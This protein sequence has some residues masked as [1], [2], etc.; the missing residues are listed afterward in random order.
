MVTVNSYM[1]VSVSF[2]VEVNIE[3]QKFINRSIF[4]PGIGM[5]KT[6]VFVV[7]FPRKKWSQKFKTICQVSFCVEDTNSE[8]DGLVLQFV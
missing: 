2:E 1:L 3:L 8:F 7:N 6:C 5:L 4:N